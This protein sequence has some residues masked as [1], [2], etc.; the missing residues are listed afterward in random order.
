MRAAAI[1]KIESIEKYIYA[2]K[3]LP[4]PQEREAWGFWKT[5]PWCIRL[6]W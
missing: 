6:S 3:E 4:Q 5:N 2:V 1:E